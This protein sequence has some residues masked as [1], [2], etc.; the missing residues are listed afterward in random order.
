MARKR[1]WRAIKLHQL[2]RLV[3]ESHENP[4]QG[5][6]QR[7]PRPVEGGSAITFV[8]HSSFLLQLGGLGLLVDPVFATRLILMRRQRR[9]GVR[10]E[11][12]P[13]I[14]AVLLSHAHMD[15]LNRPSLR[16]VVREMRRRGL[17]AP[18]AVVPNGVADLVADLGF[19]E[20]RELRWWEETSIAGMK[21][22]ATPCKHWGARMFK[23]THRGFGG[24]VLAAPGAP[25]V[26][27][28]GDTAYAPI[29]GEVG[30]RLQP[31]IALLPIGAYFPD[32]YR[33]V[34]TSPE[35]AL[36]ICEDVGAR[37]MVPMHYNTFRL[38]RE[39]FDEP[40]P[41]LLA[42]AERMGMRD[43]VHPLAEGESLIVEAGAF[44]RQTLPEEQLAGKV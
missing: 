34:H 19:R 36:Q 21:I 4:L 10:M 18:L 3:R 16:S 28:S 20:V 39:P 25:V 35:E 30:S 6:P 17:P 11:D 43:R 13:P 42:S 31:E 26:W 15:H 24:Y 38:G 22:T 23:D 27:H 37:L 9:P 7:P 33:T 32:S 5:E 41:R 1:S 14:D 40:L 2:W 29:F 44:F 12:L 8:G